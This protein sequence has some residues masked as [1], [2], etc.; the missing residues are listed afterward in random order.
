MNFLKTKLTTLTLVAILVGELVC[1]TGC[2]N[3][4]KEEMQHSYDK[5]IYSIIYRDEYS[6]NYKYHD[7]VELVAAELRERAGKPF[8]QNNGDAK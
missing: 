3:E 6:N 2:A 8:C 4:L 1:V 5:S 7:F